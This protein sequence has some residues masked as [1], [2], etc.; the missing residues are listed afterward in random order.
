MR[1]GQPRTLPLLIAIE[2][3]V[4]IYVSWAFV[5]DLFPSHDLLYILELVQKLQGR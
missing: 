1:N 5:D 4:K 3:D 2:E